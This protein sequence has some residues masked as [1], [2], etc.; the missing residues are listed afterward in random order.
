M[1]ERN[2]MEEMGI[3]FAYSFLALV[4]ILF[5][6]PIVAILAVEYWPLAQAFMGVE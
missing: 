4:L 2:P 1:S 6:V 3:A 5:F